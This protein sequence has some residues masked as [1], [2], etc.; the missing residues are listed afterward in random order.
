MQLLLLFTKSVLVGLDR[1]PQSGKCVLSNFKGAAS[2]NV[3]KLLSK[4]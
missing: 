1:N 2:R 3:N 4:R